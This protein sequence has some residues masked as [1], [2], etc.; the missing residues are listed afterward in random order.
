MSF[1]LAVWYPHRRVSDAEAGSIYQALCEEGATS[2]QA[3]PAV[4]AFYDELCA[5]HPEID[6]VPENRAGDFLGYSPWSCA[7]DRSAAQ[8]VM[9]SVW[10]EADRTHATVA[11][12]ARKHGLA[13][14]D[15]QS[16]RITYPDG[17]TAKKPKWT[18]W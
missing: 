18:V 12:L 13:L 2:L 16:E 10:S 7:H 9:C 17:D 11:A 1:D 3:H 15:P 6:D 4:D 14:Y 5:R 8:I